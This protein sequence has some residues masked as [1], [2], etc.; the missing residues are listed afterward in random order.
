MKRLTATPALAFLMIAVCT[1]GERIVLR[2]ESDAEQGATAFRDSSPLGQHVTPFGKTH[3][4]TTHKKTGRSSIRFQGGADRLEVAAGPAFVFG[5]DDFRL[6]CWLRPQ[7]QGRRFIC[8]QAPRDGAYLRASLGMVIEADGR[9]RASVQTTVRAY[10]VFAP[11]ESWDDGEWHH[12]SFRREGDEFRLLVDDKVH[13]RLFVGEEAANES[14]QPFA[15]GR[16][17]A[18]PTDPYRGYIDDFTIRR[19]PRHITDF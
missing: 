17:G 14:D 11:K 12:V 13:D 8:G 16:A 7:G 19:Q 9:L 5:T 1:A 6:E 4:S 3:H 15:I 2:V 18:F 10:L